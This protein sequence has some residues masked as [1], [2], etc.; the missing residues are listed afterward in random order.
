LA[1]PA[2]PAAHR[3]DDEPTLSGTRIRE[4]LE[5]LGYDGG[6]SIL[7]DLLRELRFDGRFGRGR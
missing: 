2:D 5:K 6:K 1:R 3:S 4:E 7:D